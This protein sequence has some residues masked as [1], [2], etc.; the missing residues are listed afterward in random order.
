MGIWRTF[1]VLTSDLFDLG[2]SRHDATGVDR[3]DASHHYANRTN[4]TF[5]AVKT[6]IIVD[7]STGLIW[8]IHCSMTQPSDS[9]IS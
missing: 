7:W 5:R 1:L 2:E 4:Y 3:I 8:D 6:T 9:Q